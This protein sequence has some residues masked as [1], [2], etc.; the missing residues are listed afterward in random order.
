MINELTVKNK[1]MVKQT[2]IYLLEE[3]ANRPGL[4]RVTLFCQVSSEDEARS[5]LKRL[6]SLKV[7]LALVDR[8]VLPVGNLAEILTRVKAIAIDGVVG[9]VTED[10]SFEDD[11]GIE[12]VKGEIEPT[13]A[14]DLIVEEAQNTQT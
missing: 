13:E 9:E 12:S 6:T 5:R 8:K 1:G 7:M 3:I 10:D 2:A 11:G 4:L 14:G